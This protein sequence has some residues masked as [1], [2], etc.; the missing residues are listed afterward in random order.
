M[1]RSPKREATHALHAHVS[2]P[3][4][5]RS[6]PGI[7]DRPSK[8]SRASDNTGI[9]AFPSSDA[10]HL[11]G[12]DS[13]NSCA[14]LA[15]LLQLQD[16][17][18]SASAAAVTAAAC[19]ATASLERRL[20]LGLALDGI[21]ND[22]S[23][24]LGGGANDTSDMRGE[25]AAQGNHAVQGV[26][27]AQGVH[28]GQGVHAVHGEH[29]G[30]GEHAV[31]ERDARASGTIDLIYSLDDEDLAGEQQRSS[32]GNGDRGRSGDTNGDLNG[33]L[34]MNEA[35]RG[36]ADDDSR[37][38][39]GGSSGRNDSHNDS[40]DDSPAD[41]SG[42]IIDAKL[43]FDER[44]DQER[45]ALADSMLMDIWQSDT[46]TREVTRHRG[47]GEDSTGGAAPMDTPPTGPDGP[48]GSDNLWMAQQLL[49][50]FK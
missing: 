30:Q 12:R 11:A 14:S 22:V 37:A 32:T 42:R 9:N 15:Q 46:S 21:A 48:P 4:P 13:P 3:E 31:H 43:Q 45:D 20:S 38:V 5:R 27:A 36:M 34:D 8:A 39:R 18:V 17:S 16:S 24:M 1:G 10:A 35:M 2:A 19:V 40:R 49:G 26:H 29:A 6:Q 47:R 23:D 50:M 28:A 44:D 33:D 41:S 25:H 7:A